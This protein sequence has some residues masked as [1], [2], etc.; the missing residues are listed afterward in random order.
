VDE[1]RLELDSPIV[2]SRPKLQGAFVAVV[3]W[4]QLR[5]KARSTGRW[6]ACMLTY[7]N[8]RSTEPVAKRFAR[9]LGM[10]DEFWLGLEQDV[11]LWD[12]HHSPAAK[13]IAKIK[14]LAE[15]AAAS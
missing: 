12:A 4:A 10:S 14:P 11:E 5:L 7:P 1:R 6:V 8:A 15:L 13:V 2:A 3:D 9:A